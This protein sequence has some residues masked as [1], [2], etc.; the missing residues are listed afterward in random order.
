M[1]QPLCIEAAWINVLVVYVNN[2]LLLVNLSCNINRINA[3]NR[4]YY[5]FENDKIFVRI[6]YNS[7][8]KF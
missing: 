2:V 6:G 8:Q 5:E 7:E 4:M 3:Y 1:I